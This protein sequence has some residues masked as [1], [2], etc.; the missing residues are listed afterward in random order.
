M[1]AVNRDFAEA[2]AFLRDERDEIDNLITALE[3]YGARRNHHGRPPEPL[4]DSPPR[5]RAKKAQRGEPI[6]A[7]EQLPNGDK[8]RGRGRPTP[9]WVAEVVEILRAVGRPLPVEDLRSRCKGIAD[10]PDNLASA[11]ATQVER[12][13]FTRP[14][15]GV[16]GLP[17]A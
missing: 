12:G 6:A 2:I 17:D 14:S 11:M 9:S 3:K 13:V 4:P 7:G 5:K 10:M 15:Y 16:Y 8:K 1:P